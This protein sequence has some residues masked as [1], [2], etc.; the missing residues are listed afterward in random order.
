MKKKILIVDDDKRINELLKDIF[1][2]EGYEV[3]C[4]FDGEEAIKA[5]ENEA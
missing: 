1:T 2:L 3:L 5:V 4:A